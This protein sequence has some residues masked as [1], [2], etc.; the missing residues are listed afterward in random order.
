MKSAL[1][2]LATISDKKLLPIQVSTPKKAYNEEREDVKGEYLVEVQWECNMDNE[3]NYENRCIVSSNINMGYSIKKSILIKLINSYDYVSAVS[4]AEGISS[5]F[6]RED[7]LRLIEVAKYR[8]MLD[9]NTCTKLLKTEDYDVFPEKSSDKVNIVEYLLYMQLKLKK[10]EYIE[11]MRAMSPVFFNILERI[12][13]YHYNFDLSKYYYENKQLNGVIMKR[14][15][16]DIANNEAILIKTCSNCDNIVKG[17]VETRQL[18]D[19]IKELG[20]A[21][22]NILEIVDRIREVEF[23]IRNPLAHGI[24]YINNDIIRKETGLTIE[25]I[26]K[27]LCTLAKKF[28]IKIDDDVLNSY[29]KLNEQIISRL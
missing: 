11:F 23:K 4:I 7:A 19:L 27:N 12:I 18:V 6:L 5:E 17:N 14:W 1:Q 16:E 28:K 25:Q 2:T 15:K 3:E 29:D 21:C 9:R 20:G 10:E 13:K 26:F 24:T 8:A 22:D